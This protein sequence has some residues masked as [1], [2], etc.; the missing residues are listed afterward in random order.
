MSNI[1][2]SETEDRLL[3]SIS[4]AAAGA[5]ILRELAQKIRFEE[6]T[7]K[8]SYDEKDLMELGKEIKQQWWEQ[9]KAKIEKDIESFSALNSTGE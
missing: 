2:I 7:N 8:A 3:I 5:E 9:N 1:S 4:K 6:L